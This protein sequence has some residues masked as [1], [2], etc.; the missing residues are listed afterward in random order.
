[1]VSNFLI[2]LPIKNEFHMNSPNFPELIIST[3]GTKALYPKT[4]IHSLTPS[5]KLNF[6]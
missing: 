3:Q 5:I 1:M 2:A 4:L 6:E